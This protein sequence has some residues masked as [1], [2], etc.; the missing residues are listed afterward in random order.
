MRYTETAET[1]RDFATF[2]RGTATAR[3]GGLRLL[4]CVGVIVGAIIT[5][6]PLAATA[7]LSH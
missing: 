2:D 3:D 4:D 5:L 6:G 7:L 1:A